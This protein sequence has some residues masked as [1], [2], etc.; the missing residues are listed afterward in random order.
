MPHAYLVVGNEHDAVLG[1]KACS[2]NRVLLS[3]PNIL[4][5]MNDLV[6]NILRA[7]KLIVPPCFEMFSVSKA[8]MMLQKPL[9]F[10]WCKNDVV[11]FK[12]SMSFAIEVFSVR[13]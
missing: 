4:G 11:C 6:V 12:A 7:G 3:D 1:S 9:P 2:R 13:C 10:A 8:S 5:W